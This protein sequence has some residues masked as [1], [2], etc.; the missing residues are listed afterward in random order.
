M[1]FKPD[2]T[3]LYRIEVK[4]TRSAPWHPIHRGPWT[5]DA[6]FK[7]WNNT[8]MLVRVVAIVSDD[9]IAKVF[10]EH[11]DLA[12]TDEFLDRWYSIEGNA[13]DPPNRTAANVKDRRLR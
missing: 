9:E 12:G 3:R 4:Y 8:A 5:R 2:P 11:P 13:G 10:N 7:Y 6:A 1:P